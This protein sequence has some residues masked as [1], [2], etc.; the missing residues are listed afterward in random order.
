MVRNS[1][2]VC[3]ASGYEYYM[4]RCSLIFCF[5]FFLSQIP[6]KCYILFCLR[7]NVL[8]RIFCIRFVDAHCNASRFHSIQLNTVHKIHSVPFKI[9]VS[10]CVA[11]RTHR[12]FVTQ[13]RIQN[14][15]VFFFFWVFG[16][17]IRI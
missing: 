1:G 14:M 2:R 11:Y 10:M 12:T 5:V 3:A 8:I 6:I 7:A 16:F 9:D 4:V 13:N 17:N 15:F